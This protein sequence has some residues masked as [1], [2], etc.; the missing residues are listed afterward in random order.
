MSSRFASSVITV[1]VAL[2]LQ[3][4]AHANE[5]LMQIE[6]IIVSVNRD[7]TAQAIQLRT[8]A[9]GQNFV[10]GGKLVV[11]DHA[12]NNPVTVL[13]LGNDV[14]NGASGARVLIASQTFLT[15]T[16]PTTVPDFLIDN[17]IPAGY[18]AAGSLVWEDDAGSTVWWRLSWG[19][20]KYTGPKTGATFND[21]NG[22]FG[23]PF[24][25]ALPSCAIYGLRFQKGATALSTSNNADYKFDT[26]QAES[27][28][29]NAGKTFN[30]SGPKPTVSVATLDANANEFPVTDTGKFR[31][32]RTGCNGVAQS[33]VYAMSGT[34]TNGTDYQRLSGKV[35]IPVG[36]ASANVVVKA[37]NDATPEGN[38][39][40]ILTLSP[41]V[42]Y[43]IAA[44][45]SG[46]V[47][48]HSNE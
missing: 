1:A 21:A 7:T 8:R 29:N 20:A 24:A 41:N 27:F 14:T 39:T 3:S 33:I 38:E 44:P 19:G 15:R 48:I 42:A 6:K 40:A 13:N 46:T 10:H 36:Q 25:S 17:V 35:N 11:F 34:A 9:P 32:T 43:T 22:N 26:A 5:H 4:G 2:A 37:I 45:N 23:P 28:V 16:S 12:G 47:I 31:V 18:F 30:L